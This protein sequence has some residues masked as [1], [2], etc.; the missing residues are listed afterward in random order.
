VKTQNAN[1]DQ[2]RPRQTQAPEPFGSRLP[3]QRELVDVLIV[4]NGAERRT[5][6]SVRSE[7]I[8]PLTE[9]VSQ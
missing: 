5:G 8:L 9:P 2:I 7:L 4:Q 6:R 3:L 1:I